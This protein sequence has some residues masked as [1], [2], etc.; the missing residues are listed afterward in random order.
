MYCGARSRNAPRSQVEHQ[1]ARQARQHP[2]LAQTPAR[3]MRKCLAPTGG[4][5]PEHPHHRQHPGLKR[6]LLP[7]RHAGAPSR[8][9]M[10]AGKDEAH[11][12]R[13]RSC[14]TSQV[15]RAS[16]RRSQRP[17]RTAA[18][19]LPARRER[20]QR[21]PPSHGRLTLPGVQRVATPWLP[22]AQTASPQTP[23]EQPQQ[24]RPPLPARATRAAPGAR[25]P[26][27]TRA[28]LC[29]PLEGG[30]LP[31]SSLPQQRQVQLA[32]AYSGV[33][34]ATRGQQLASARQPAV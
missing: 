4:R 17:G 7:S 22:R 33:G 32:A 11:S 19:G 27:A 3:T 6:W 8:S 16:R 9:G 26:R 21:Q 20:A 15:E 24:Q 23:Q 31:V 14:H 13:G 2:A 29:W 12:A 18:K 34:L 5:P 25:V 30:M 28:A 1:A 10:C